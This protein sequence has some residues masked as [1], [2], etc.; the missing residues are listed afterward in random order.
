MPSNS[1]VDNFGARQP[2]PQSL[3]L[4]TRV[5]LVILPKF[6]IVE[7]HI[8]EAIGVI[9]RRLPL[10]TAK[11]S[12]AKLLHLRPVDISRSLDVQDRLESR[13]ELVQGHGSPLRLPPSTQSRSQRPPVA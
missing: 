5:V 3:A 6:R 12:R 11:R 10:E 13:P 9:G 2:V 8:D 4:D 1:A 7:E